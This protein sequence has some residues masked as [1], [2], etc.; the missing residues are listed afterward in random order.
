MQP[1]SYSAYLSFVAGLESP[2]D[3]ARALAD[4]GAGGWTILRAFG[5][6]TDPATGLVVSEPS[7]A[8]LLLGVAEEEADQLAEGLRARFGQS[9]VWSLPLEAGPVRVASA[10]QAAAAALPVARPRSK[11]SLD[12]RR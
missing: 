4:L 3:L 9:E 10:G 1:R 11:A 12:A 5:G 2:D 8:V 7:L 6:W